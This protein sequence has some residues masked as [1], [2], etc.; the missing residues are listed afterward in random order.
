MANWVGGSYVSRNQKGDPNAVAPIRPVEAELQREA[1]QFVVQ[2]AFYDEAFGL[3][4]EMLKHMTTESWFDPGNT[5]A[6]ANWPV[7]DRI[8]G[9]QAS[10]LTAIMNPTTLSRVYDNEFIVA[11][12]EDALT[13]HEVVTTVTD[14]VWEE[15]DGDMTKRYTVR[16]PMISSMRRNLQSEHVDRLIDLTMPGGMFGAAARPISNLSRMALKD[17]H[18]Q[19]NEMLDDASA[20]RLDPY[21]RAHLLEVSAKV[22]KALDAQFIYNA[23]M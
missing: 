9:I 16:D 19:V 8:L 10:M 17:L 5:L 6:E 12:D 2:N 1:L 3:T 23:S 21:T 13:L 22:E 11:P 4:P 15:L 20:N 14:A 7:H 18:A